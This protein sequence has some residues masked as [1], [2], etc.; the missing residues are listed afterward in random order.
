MWRQALQ[1]RLHWLY[2]LLTARGSP[3]EGQ[4]LV[5]YALLLVLVVLVAFVV[6]TVLGPWV[7]NI[8]S[9]LVNVL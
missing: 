7:G 5:E 1:A 9:N 4:G 2:A 6:V 3:R 8:Y